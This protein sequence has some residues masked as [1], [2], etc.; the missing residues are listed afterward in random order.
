MVLPGAV[1]RPSEL[2]ESGFF[3]FFPQL[4]TSKNGSEDHVNTCHLDILFPTR[5]NFY[6][7][8][9]MSVAQNLKC[10]DSYLCF[11]LAL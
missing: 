9:C 7:L 6:L 11:D 8:S 10:S 3:L 5:W 4:Y 1:T 2:Q